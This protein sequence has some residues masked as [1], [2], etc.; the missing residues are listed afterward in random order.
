MNSYVFGATY[1]DTGQPSGTLV[2]E[3]HNARIRFHMRTG[4]SMVTAGKRRVQSERVTFRNGTTATLAGLLILPAGAAARSPV[5]V[6][7]HGGGDND[8]YDLWSLA[9][10]VVDKGVGVLVFDKRNVG[11]SV[12]DTIRGDSYYE[13][14]MQTVTDAIA[15]V[16]FAQQHAAVDSTRVGHS[17]GGWLGAIVAR[18]VPN[19][20]FYVNIAGNA[21]PGWE[22]WR[23]AMR[24]WM[25]RQ[26]FTAAEEASAGSYLDAFFA[27][28]TQ[29]DWP[30]YSRRLASV[31][32]STW[33]K[34]LS[35][36][37]SVIWDS[38]GAPRAFAAAEQLNVPALDYQRVKVPALGLFFE[39]DGS[40]TPESPEIFLSA[41]RR[42]GNSDVTVAVFPGA[43]HGM[44]LVDS[45]T[46]PFAAITRRSVDAPELVYDWIRAKSGLSRP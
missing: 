18:E 43:Q 8:R 23:H 27:Q 3:R 25:K 28:L 4:G 24:M 38:A 46:T 32:D 9:M 1:T 15:A 29:T 19:L 30:G 20:R 35:G 37:Y 14:S 16:R 21:S 39:F 41:L 40:T 36:R 7:L 34:R 5:A 10:G 22:Q 45:Y 2:F 33:F 6:M 11:E 12:G 26:G 42:A 31:R 13:Q 44:W 17:Q